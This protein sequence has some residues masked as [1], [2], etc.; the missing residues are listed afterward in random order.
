MVPKCT[1]FRLATQFILLF[2]SMLLVSIENDHHLAFSTE[3]GTV[4]LFSR[5]LNKYKTFVT[6]KL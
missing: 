2:L 1:F 6:T 5:C 3:Q 4:T